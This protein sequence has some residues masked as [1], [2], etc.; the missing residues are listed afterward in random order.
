MPDISFDY[1][2]FLKTVPNRPGSYRMYS[3]EQTV[4]YVGKAADLKKRLSSY[5]LKQVGIKTAALIRHI[6]HIEFT[7]TFSEAE[8]LILENELIKKYQPHY[9]ILLRD[10]KSYPYL[11][12]TKDKHPGLFFHRGPRRRMGDYFGPYPDVTAVRESMKLIQKLFPIRQCADNVYEHRSRPCLLAQIGKCLAP[13]VLMTEAQEQNY[14]LQVEHVRMFLKGQDQALLNDLR[15]QMEQ[16]SAS[17]NFEAAAKVRDQMLSLRKVQEQNSISGDLMFDIDVLAAVIKEG[18][19]CVHALFIRH[20][21]V[22]GTRSYY[23]EIQKEDEEDDVLE[24]SLNQF[25][26]NKNFGDMY[27]KEIVLQI[28][29]DRDL[30]VLALALKQ[31]SGREIKFLRSV[32]AERA[33]YLRLA[34]EN[35]NASLQAKLTSHLTAEKRIR[36]LEKLLHINNVKHM[37]CF[38]ISHTMGELTVASCVSFNREGPDKQRYRRFNIEG[39]TPGDDFAAMHQVLSRRFKNPDDALIPDLVFIDGGQGQLRQAEEV[40]ATLFKETSTKAPLLVAVAKGE[41]RK[42]GLE[43]L[44][45]G[46]SHEQYHLSL[47][48]PALQLV[49]HIRDESHRFAIT[50]HRGRRLKARVHSPLENIVGVGPKKRKALLER[51]GGMRELVRAGVDEIKKVPGFS[52]DLAQNVYDALHAL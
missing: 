52:E 27:P 1:K 43:T 50:G 17:L 35:A 49:L 20:G 37:E 6:H 24:A 8:A 30:S 23:P 14:A 48:D 16:L 28:S 47:E 51:F 21:R 32:R 26:L 7:V 15:T 18:I 34:V 39:I 44:I 3:D 45:M 46:Y 42:E 41:G 9:N 13:C 4:I 40:I 38:D 19:A 33:K 36:A 5:F 25:Y 10:D 31:V 2:N 22:I 12:L 29:E 11:L